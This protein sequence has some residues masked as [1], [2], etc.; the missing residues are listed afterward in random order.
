[1]SEIAIGAAHSGTLVQASVG[2]TLRLEIGENPTTG[3]RWQRDD[4]DELLESSGDRFAPPEGSAA[5]AGGTRI[6]SFRAVGAGRTRLEL[7]MRQAWEPTVPP[8]ETYEVFVE[9]SDGD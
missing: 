5:G 6:L 8:S 9:I 4:Q 1:M 3:F 2:D 7:S